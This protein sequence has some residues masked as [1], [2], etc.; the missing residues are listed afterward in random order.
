MQPSACE[1]T[2]G[3]VLFN[4]TPE[5]WRDFYFRVADEAP[6][7]IVY[8]GE[9]ICSKR[10]PLF[11]PE[12]EAV[13]SRLL[14][15]GKT[16]VFSTLTEV[17]SKADRKLVGSVT[18]ADSFAVEVNDA[19]ALAA[20][21][22]RPHVIGPYMNVYNERTLTVL[23]RGGAHSVCL[24]AEVPATA[25]RALCEE[26]A[27][28]G[29]AVEV[30][31]FGRMPL[32]LSARCYHARAHGRTKDSCQF[33]CEKDADGME[34]R[35]LEDKPFLAVN[36]IQTLSYEY[37]NLSGELTELAAIGVSRFRMSPHSGDMVRV[38]SLFRAVLDGQLA[39]SEA[40]AQLDA[41]KPPGPF[42]NGFYYGKPG[43]TWTQTATT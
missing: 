12:L 2:L 6:V 14:T 34:L 37:L 8:L 23:A 9:V 15:A 10:A 31:A 27:K 38:A 28:L 35:T 7:T 25:M 42:C 16:V 3:P 17:M 32:A 5:V 36:G 22:G 33:V 39:A 29:V 13:A 18:E 4:W 1:L 41:A 20:L 43:F 19:S 21:R 26:A 30:Q 24:P 11:E 40:I